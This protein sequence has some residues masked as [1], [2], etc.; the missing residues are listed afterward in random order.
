MLDE[1]GRM[2]EGTGGG[3]RARFEARVMRVAWGG[4]RSPG[5]G[6][7]ARRTARPGGRH[8]G[9][10]RARRRERGPREG[11]RAQGRAERPGGERGLER[12]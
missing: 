5:E 2:V 3:Q 7:G 1:A 6:G 4:Q 10:R 8:R 11:R 9:G 12:E